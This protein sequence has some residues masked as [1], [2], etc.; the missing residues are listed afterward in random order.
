MRLINF[1]FIIFSI[2]TI[3]AHADF[4]GKVISV[5]DGDTITVLNDSKKQIRVRLAS[6]DAPEKNQPFGTQAKKFTSK[7]IFGKQVLIKNEGSD[8][9]NRVLGTAYLGNQNIN[10]VIVYNGYAWA[11]RRYIKDTS[12]ISL[13]MDAKRHQRG[14]W[15]DKN[16]IEPELWRRQQKNR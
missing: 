9:Y 8:Q 13:E 11:Y 1:G 7:L 14:L 4:Q 15:S 10:K 16:A 12:Y 3:K 6:I 5:S 2:I